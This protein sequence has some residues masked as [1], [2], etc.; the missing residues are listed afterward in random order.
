MTIRNTTF[1]AV[2]AAVLASPGLPA[3]DLSP[4]SLARLGLPA[5]PSEFVNEVA[6]G[7]QS[8]WDV[9]AAGCPSGGG[10]AGA[11]FAAMM[12]AAETDA[13][14]LRE[15]AQKLGDELLRAR[16][17]EH[18][19]VNHYEVDAVGQ[20]RPVPMKPQCPS[21]LPGHEAWLAAQ[22]RREWERGLL[23]GESTVAGTLLRA[24]VSATAPEAF[25][26]VRGIARDPAV[27][28]PWREDAADR[29]AFL[30]FGEGNVNSPQVGSPRW[31]PYI[32]AYQAALFDLAAGAP[33][34]EYER[35]GF[36]IV[37]IG[38]GE[39]RDVFEREYEQA[40]RAAGREPFWK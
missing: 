32:D 7:E 13:H 19:R 4:D 11:A 16:E 15:L 37:G 2:A 21:E 38:R 29:L 26:V 20:R 6:A 22:L 17:L 1:A 10:W 27:W 5:D 8:G 31:G 25:E 18:G 14:V 12:A 40:L 24:I 39:A 23:A 3:Q 36:R 9:F 33:L 30:Y 34:P 35:E 28:E